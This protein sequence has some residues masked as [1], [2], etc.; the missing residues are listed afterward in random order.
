M[1]ILIICICLLIVEAI[2]LLLV[3]YGS[4]AR[5]ERARKIKE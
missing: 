2:E 3:L 4:K 1:E 5:V